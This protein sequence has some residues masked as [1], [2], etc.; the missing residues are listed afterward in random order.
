MDEDALMAFLR[1][2]L[3]IEVKTSSEYCGGDG[4]G[5]MF[6]DAHTI[7]L[8]LDGESISEASL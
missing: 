5:R 6:R 7:V 4:S 2:H 3:S 1:G 8:L